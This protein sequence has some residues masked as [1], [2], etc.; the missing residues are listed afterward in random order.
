MCTQSRLLLSL[1]QQFC[2]HLTSA[3]CACLFAVLEIIDSER[4]VLFPPSSAI[5]A[6]SQQM[7]AYREWRDSLRTLHGIPVDLLG[8]RPFFDGLAHRLTKVVKIVN[9]SHEFQ[10]KFTHGF[11][12]R[13]APFPR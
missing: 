9:L 7:E 2:F 5:M 1:L 11:T 10:I 13:R 4:P 3:S 8:L 12:V 6:Y